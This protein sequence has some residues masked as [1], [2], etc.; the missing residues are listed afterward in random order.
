MT[1][2]GSYE[3]AYVKYRMQYLGVVAGAIACFGISGLATPSVARAQDRLSDSMSVDDSLI[4]T[5]PMDSMV[6]DSPPPPIPTYDQPPVMAPGYMWTPGYWAWGDAGYYWVPGAWVLPPQPGYLWTPG[7][8]GWNTIGF[9]WSPGYW[10]PRVGFYGGIN[11]GF[12]YFGT[13]YAGGRWHG[14]RF[15]YNTAITRVNTRVVTNV[16]VNR[17]VVVNNS[18]VSYNGGG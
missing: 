10:G 2:G 11:Y 12:G 15:F 3:R 6:V 7:Y 4:D 1:E 17:T 8:W 5:M 18:H 13:G 14:G 16:Y 9:V